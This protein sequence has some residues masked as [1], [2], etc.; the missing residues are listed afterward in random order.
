MRNTKI[1]SYI[2][3]FPY[4]T[5]SKKLGESIHAKT[6]LLHKPALSNVSLEDTTRRGVKLRHLDIPLQP[7]T[8]Q[9]M[10]G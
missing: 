1:E 8:H 5:I 4:P 7:I 9:T 3:H 6:N 2:D 10:I